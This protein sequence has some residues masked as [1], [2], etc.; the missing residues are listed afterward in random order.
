MPGTVGRRLAPEAEEIHEK[1]WLTGGRNPGPALGVSGTAG[2]SVIPLNA[3]GKESST[4]A[5]QPTV[6][7]CPGR[8]SGQSDS[9]RVH[10]KFFL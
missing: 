7:G 4:G 3:T 10:T 6:P 1:G 8:L 5:R 2:Q 9:T